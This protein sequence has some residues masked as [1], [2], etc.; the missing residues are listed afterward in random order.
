MAF[1]TF[2]KCTFGTG[3]K[4]IFIIIIP[5]TLGSFPITIFPLTWWYEVSPG[6]Y[7]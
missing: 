7:Y 5:N 4:S 1:Q 2:V 3:I 6:H